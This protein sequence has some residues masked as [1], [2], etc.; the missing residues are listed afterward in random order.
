MGLRRMFLA[1]SVF[2]GGLALFLSLMTSRPSPLPPPIIGKN[3]TALFISNSEHGLS[4][5]HVATAQA[6]LEH[7]PH[8][9][10]HFASFPA[11]G[12]RLQRVSSYSQK[13]T[14][15]AK[16]IVFHPIDGLS[17]IQACFAAGQRISDAIQPPGRAGIKAA[18]KNIQLFI[19]PW[20]GESHLS[21]Y[22][23][24]KQILTEVDPAVVV[25][26][27][28]LRPALDATRD[29]NRLHA[30]ITPNTLI[31]NFPADQPW[32]AMLWKYPCPG[33]GIPYPVP[34]N[35]MAENIYLNLQFI[36]SILFMPD[37][38]SKQAFLKSKGLRDPINFFG[39][40]RPDVP[41]L[42]QTMS[43]AS[44]PVDVVPQNVT[45]TGPIVLSLGPAEEQDPALAAWLSRAPTVLVNLGGGFIYSE[46]AATA[47]A[48]GLAEVLDSTD[49]QILWKFRS[50]SPYLEA[51]EDYGDDFKA[52]L[53][54]FLDNERIKIES[55]LPIDPP[56]ILESGHVVASVHHGGAGCYHE[57]I[58]AGVPQVVLPQWLDLYNFA[59]LVEYIEVGV[60]GCPKTSPHWTP[61][62]IREAI[63]RTIDK[64]AASVAMQN[65]ARQLAKITQENP[66]KY[67][68]AQ[69]IAKL[70]QSGKEYL[71]Q[72]N[73][74]HEGF[75]QD[76]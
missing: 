51:G 23:Q 44:V 39:L 58:S 56:A 31:D 70:A 63:L 26:D 1:G 47:M 75:R 45:C 5:V 66:G 46:A 11:L 25:L 20:S 71:D 74:S 49:V 59:Q 52:P 24:V 35:R 16:E 38:K 67:V 41:W 21:M 48:K 40:H 33:S 54:P 64:S 55:W 68:A 69:E 15:A 3:N 4:N 76:L 12:P 22:E 17:L 8:I 73:D 30:F 14:A 9:Q 29:Q 13:K 27:T 53:K 42:T 36:S 6:L 2:I 60:W 57:A 43:E 18:C 28:L 32:A 62:C 7:Y 19:S 72:T 10:V 61:E 50:R 65:K 34:W 37:I